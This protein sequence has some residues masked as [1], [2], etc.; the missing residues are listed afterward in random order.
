MSASEREH[1]EGCGCAGFPGICAQRPPKVEPDASSRQL[2][3][4]VRQ[5]Y[6]ALRAAGFNT[7]EACTIIGAQLAGMIGGASEEDT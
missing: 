2:A 7:H 3:L 6:V 5:W 4:A 1:P